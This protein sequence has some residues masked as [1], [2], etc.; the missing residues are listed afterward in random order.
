[1]NLVNECR[2]FPQCLWN[3]ILIL[4]L[5]SSSLLFTNKSKTLPFNK[6]THFRL[7]PVLSDSLYLLSIH[8]NIYPLS[9]LFPKSDWVCSSVTPSAGFASLKTT[10][11]VSEGHICWFGYVF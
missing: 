7:I 10:T 6:L 11:K 8:E 4:P 5:H 1:M 2:L 3:L 9:L